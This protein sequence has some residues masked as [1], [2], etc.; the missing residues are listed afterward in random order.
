MIADIMIML[1]P[2]SLLE[3]CPVHLYIV[4]PACLSPMTIARKRKLSL[5]FINK[6]VPCQYVCCCTHQ[7]ERIL[8]DLDIV[9]CAKLREILAEILLFRLPGQTTN[10]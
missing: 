2:N 7:S 1:M 6:S 4:K 3:L 9:D 10:K 8:H 5:T